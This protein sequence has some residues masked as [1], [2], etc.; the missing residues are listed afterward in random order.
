MNN[1]LQ[2]DVMFFCPLKVRRDELHFAS[3]FKI[4]ARRKNHNPRLGVTTFG[5]NTAVELPEEPKLESPLLSDPN[6]KI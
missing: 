3:T 5:D 6:N 4:L 2:C 1:Q